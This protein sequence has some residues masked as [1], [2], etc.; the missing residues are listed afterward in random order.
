MITEKAVLR[1]NL[2]SIIS[3]FVLVSLL[4]WIDYLTGPELIFSIFYLFPIIIVTWYCSIKY[5]GIIFC[6]I[7]AGVL[8]A[9]D[10]FTQYEY[11]NL[12]I[13]FWSMSVHLVFF[14][15]ITKLLERIKKH[16]EKE[17]LL[18]ITDPLTGV[19]NS[20]QYYVLVDSEIKRHI[21]YGSPFTLLFIDVDDF[22]VVNDTSG[23]S[24]GDK[25]LKH[26]TRVVNSGV[27]STDTVA[28]LGGDEFSILL[29]EVDYEKAETTISKIRK[30]LE[31]SFEDTGRVVTFSIG[32][33]T[34]LKSSACTADDIIRKADELMYVVKRSG[35]NG[36]RH[37]VVSD[38]SGAENCAGV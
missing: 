13:P 17:Q 4:G 3:S 37:E 12:L 15:I 8:F 7:S 16:L 19:V 32:A 1:K 38:E 36:L 14:L 5:A 9:S 2:A 21:R 29:P 31:S 30:M 25:L 20:R 28:R 34:I 18:A 11:K 10:A 24:E 6:F 27:R 22:K 23:H 33:I 26:I 35:K